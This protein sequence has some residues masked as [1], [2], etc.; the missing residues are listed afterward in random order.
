[1]ASALA[2]PLPGVC[3]A[4]VPSHRRSCGELGEPLRWAWLSLPLLKKKM[5][6]SLSLRAGTKLCHQMLLRVI[7]WARIWGQRV[8]GSVRLMT[9]TI[10]ICV[11][12]LLC[13]Q[14]GRGLLG[15][16]SRRVTGVAVCSPGDA[17]RGCC[18]G[19]GGGGGNL[20]ESRLL[21]LLA[22]AVLVF[23]LVF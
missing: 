10:F 4:A 2:V 8:A 16:K 12:S 3:R 18:R 7:D 6:L 13:L 17:V 11:A 9:R 20:P 21:P 23:A 19:T 5:Y 22:S 1:M 15:R 14:S